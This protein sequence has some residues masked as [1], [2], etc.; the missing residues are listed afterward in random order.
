MIGFPEVTVKVREYEAFVKAGPSV[1]ELLKKT[2]EME[3]E[4]NR[5]KNILIEELKKMEDEG[6]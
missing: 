3:I 6:I 2:S 5:V 1:S 4:V